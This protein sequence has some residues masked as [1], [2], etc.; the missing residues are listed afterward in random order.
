MNSWE[1]CKEQL[2]VL[3][4]KD[5]ELRRREGLRNTTVLIPAGRRARRAL[6][7]EMVDRR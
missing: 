4:L 7:D 1:E 6:K 3:R 2:Y 5:R